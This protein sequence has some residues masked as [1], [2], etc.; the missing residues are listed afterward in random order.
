MPSQETFDRAMPV[1]GAPD[2][3]MP[4]RPGLHPPVKEHIIRKII[5]GEKSYHHQL[6]AE[7]EPKGF[8]HADV[9]FGTRS[10]EPKVDHVKLGER[11]GEEGGPGLPI[12][13]PIPKGDRIPQGD[14]VGVGGPRPGVTKSVPVGMKCALEVAPDNH[15]GG[16]GRLQIPDVRMGNASL[17][18]EPLLDISRHGGWK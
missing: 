9:L 17:G 3:I 15:P 8:I 4:V 5:R 6:R 12:V 7:G 11:L 13:H 1:K 16:V 2:E 18:R 14:N 10:N